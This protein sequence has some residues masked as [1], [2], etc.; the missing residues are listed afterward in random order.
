MRGRG[1][2]DGPLLSVE[3]LRIRF[4]SRRD[5]VTAVDGV[6]FAMDR[7]E[8]VALIGE[9]GSGKSAT[10]LAI[11]GF[12]AR[13]IASVSAT[14]LDFDGCPL[15]ARRLPRIP[16]RTPGLTMVFQDAMTSLDPVWTVGAQLAAVLT[17]ARRR[18]RAE[19][20]EVSAPSGATTR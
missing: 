19:V 12:L 8:R 11:A 13:G 9:S 15:L 6:S 2:A 4:G 1:L 17:A 14:R 18:N 7:G 16:V 5:A 20:R 3:D 10:C